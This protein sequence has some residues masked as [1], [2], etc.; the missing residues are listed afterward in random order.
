MS[1]CRCDDAPVKGHSASYSEAKTIASMARLKSG[2][3]PCAARRRVATNDRCAVVS[4]IA[5]RGELA[6]LGA[7]NDEQFNSAGVDVS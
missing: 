7:K 2:E 5:C 4:S 3:H 1:S 6:E